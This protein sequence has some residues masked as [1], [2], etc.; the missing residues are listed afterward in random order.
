MNRKLYLYTALLAAFA[1]ISFGVMQHAVKAEPEFIEIDE[2]YIVQASS[3]NGKRTAYI[4]DINSNIVYVKDSD[5]KSK[6][7]LLVDDELK[8]ATAVY[9]LHWIN[10]DTLGIIAHVNPSLEYL[11]I[12]SLPDYKII[13]EH[14]GTFFDWAADDY[15]SLYYIE[16]TPHFS[17]QVAPEAIL[18]YQEQVIYETEG[19]ISLSHLTI[20]PN[21]SKIAFFGIDKE[22]EDKTI[23]I[24]SSKKEDGIMP[25][26]MDTCIAWDGE[27]GEL[28]W[29]GENIITVSTLNK[30]TN[31]NVDT[32]ELY[33]N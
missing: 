26:T 18:D 8:L 5:S 19:G 33:M 28:H 22:N 31:I 29:N 24:I 2:P 23:H 17:D 4:S 12:Y 15:T 25:L 27:V 9:D 3:E 11:V 30:D 10:N 21:G 14:Y 13:D 20:S 32:G 1:V 16:P 6:K 7:E